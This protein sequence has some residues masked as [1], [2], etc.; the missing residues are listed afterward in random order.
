MI[1]EYDFW[2]II[3]TFVKLIQNLFFCCAVELHLRSLTCQISWLLEVQ[4]NPQRIQP[5]SRYGLNYQFFSTNYYMLFPSGSFFTLKIIL[6]R[7]KTFLTQ[8]NG[9]IKKK[10]GQVQNHLG[11]T[12]RP[13]IDE[14]NFYS[15]AQKF[16]ASIIGVLNHFSIS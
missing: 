13:G 2:I 7:H 12:K 8:K 1:E 14:Q 3:W 6:D 9:P 16:Y 11:H 15:N 4:L 10:I 5:Y